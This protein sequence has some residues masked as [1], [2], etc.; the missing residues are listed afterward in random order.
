MT[1]LC[2][3]IR[4]LLS[5]YMIPKYR[6]YKENYRYYIKVRITSYYFFHQ[7]S[8]PA[9]MYDLLTYQRAERKAY[10]KTYVGLLKASA[11]V[12]KNENMICFPLH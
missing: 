3:H 1:A 6:R 10:A 4:N 7:Y 9:K 12:V 2:R 8:G 5:D 11:I